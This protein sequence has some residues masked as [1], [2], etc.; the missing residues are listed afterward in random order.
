M[1]SN[2]YQAPSNP[3]LTSSY[4]NN[5]NSGSARNDFH[6]TGHTGGEK[7]SIQ[8]RASETSRLLTLSAEPTEQTQPGDDQGP[9][10]R[11]DAAAKL[12]QELNQF[13]EV[14]TQLRRNLVP[15]ATFGDRCR[16]AFD[17][18]NDLF[19]NAPTWVCFYRE[20]MAGGGLLQVLFNADKDFSAFLK[21]DQHHQI[22]SMLTALRGRDLPE[23]DP[24][25]PQRMITVRLP[26]SLHEAMCEEAGRLNISVNRLCISRMLQLL[27]PEMIPETNSKPRGRKPRTRSKTAANPAPSQTP[28]QSSSQTPSQTPPA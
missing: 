8:D 20:L 15:A 25:D 23:N 1:N 16:Q 2:S 3:A 28:I 7:L 11:N 17:V 6:S 27:D 5:S 4:N 19:A 26:K 13:T 14:A 10:P 12:A 24:N 22:Q 18:A 21:T 9:A